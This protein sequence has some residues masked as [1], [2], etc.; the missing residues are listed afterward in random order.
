[1]Q[2]ARQKDGCLFKSL[3]NLFVGS[4]LE[5][6][7]VFGGVPDPRPGTSV[8]TVVGQAEQSM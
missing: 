2:I 7:F 1:M 4:H 3:R 5:M 6:F 8:C